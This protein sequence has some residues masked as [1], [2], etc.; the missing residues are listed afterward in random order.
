MT[1]QRKVIPLWPRE[2]FI[3]HARRKSVGR[4]AIPARKASGIDRIERQLVGF[5]VKVERD[6]D[7]AQWFSVVGGGQYR[8]FVGALFIIEE[9]FQCVRNRPLT[10]PLR[11]VAVLID[12]ELN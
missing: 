4:W 8:E 2:H 3:S 6:L 9:I 5:G 12:K 7:S 1:I 11:P 10:L